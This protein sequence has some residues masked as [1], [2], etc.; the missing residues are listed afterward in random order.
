LELS[1]DSV[2]VV[3]NKRKVPQRTHRALREALRAGGPGPIPWRKVSKARAARDAV[4]K[5]VA[6]GVE[7][8]IVCGGDGTVRAAAEALVDTGVALAV[9]PTGTANAFAR[10]LDLP[11]EPAG[12]VDM[13]ASGHRTLVDTGRCND[14]TFTVMAGMGFD[15]AMVDETPTRLKRRLGALSYLRSAVILARHREPFDVAVVVDGA[16]FFEGPATCILTAN[17]GRLAGGLMAFPH[18]S[19]T[20]G[21]LDIAVITAK[22]LRQWSSLLVRSACGQQDRSTYAKLTQGTAISVRLDRK[23]RFEVDGG[24]KG[25]TDRLD[26]SVRPESLLLCTPASVG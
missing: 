12:V 17:L 14:L 3:E 24:T 23:H 18:A 9:V 2:A 20:D 10:G 26:V 19:A 6:E 4:A 22:G 15:A 8:V 25:S 16:T 13:V 21:R 5:A 11:T 7:T 1:V